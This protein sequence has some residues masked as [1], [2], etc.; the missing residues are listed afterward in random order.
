VQ[1]ATFVASRDVGQAVGRF[2]CKFLEDF[3][4]YNS[5]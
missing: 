5:A 1:A 4:F 2:E 3:H